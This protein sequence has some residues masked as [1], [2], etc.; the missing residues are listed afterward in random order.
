M[1][2]RNVEKPGAMSNAGV[3]SLRETNDDRGL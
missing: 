1:E 2:M 3:E